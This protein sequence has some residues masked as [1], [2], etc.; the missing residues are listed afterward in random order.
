M[1]A[2][3]GLI[4]S[5]H[6][7]ACSIGRCTGEFV[8]RSETLEDGTEPD[9]KRNKSNMSHVGVQFRVRLTRGS[10]SG[11]QFCIAAGHELKDI[12]DGC[13]QPA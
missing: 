13:I 11:L 5:F 7:E 10:T 12:S 6:S 3:H 4:L 1:A 2:S 9:E 8:K